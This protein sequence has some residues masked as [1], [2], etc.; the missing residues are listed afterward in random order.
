[1]SS[2]TSQQTKLDLELVPKENRLNIDKC[3]GRI[4]HKLTPREPTFQLILDVIALTSCY[5]AFLI[6]ADVPEVYMH[7]FWNS[8]YK[9][10]TFY[11][12]KIDKKKRFKLTL[13]VFRDIFQIFPRVSGRDFDPLPFEEDT[14]SF[15]RELGHMLLSIRCINPREL[16]L[17]LSI[18]FYL[19][20]LVVLTSFVSPELKSFGRNKIRM[21]TSKDDYLINSLRFVSAKESTQ[22]YGAIL[23]ECLTSPAMK[24]SK[25]YKTYLGYATG[26]VPPKMAQKFKKASPSKKDSDL[27]PVDEEPVQKGKRV[28]RPA[29][30][31]TTKPAA[32][33]VIREAPVETKSKSKEKEKVDVTRGKGIELLSEVALTEEA[34]MKEVRKKSLRDFHKTHPS[35]SGTVAEKPPSVDKITPIGNDEDDNKN[36]QD[37]SN[38]DSEQ[39]N[40]SEEQV[41]DSEQEEESEDDDQEEEEFVHTPFPTDDK[42][43]DNLESESD[44]VIKSDEKSDDVIKE[45]TQEQVF[46]DAHVKIPTITK[47]IEVPLTSSSYVHVHH[48]V[49][50]TQAPTLLTIPVFVITESSPVYTNIPQSSQTV[51]PLPILTTPN[52]PPTIETTNPL[53]TLLDFVSV[54]QFNDRI[55]ALEKEV[56]KLKKDPLHTQSFTARIKEQVKDQLPHILP[57]EVSNFA[58]PVIEKLIKESCDEV[59]LAKVSSQPHSTYEA[60]STL[61]EFELKKILLDKMEKSESYLAAPKHQDCYDS[62][63]KSYDLDKA[64]FF[65]YDVH[66]LKRS[67]KD[68]DK[69]EDP[70]A[71]SD[72]GLKKRKL[73]KD[74]EPT[75]GLKKKDS[76]S[77][78]SKGTKSQPKSSGKS[79]QSEEP[80]FEVADSDMPQD[81]EGNMG[82]N[83]D[84]PRKE[85]ASR[86]P[87]QN[88]LLTL[89]ASTSTDK[90]LKDFDELMSTPIDFSG[91][92]L[93]GLKIKNLTQEILLGPAFRLLKGTH[94]N[95][96]EL[97]YDFKECYKALL[98]KL[99]WENPEGGDYL[100]DLSKPL[101]LITHGKHQRVPFKYFINNDL[102]YLQAGVSTMTY[103]TGIQSR[104]DVYS[105]KRILAVTHVKLMRKHGY[106]YLE[107][108]VVRRADN[109]LYRFKEGDFPRLQINDIEDMLILVVQN[110]LINLLGDDVAD[111]AIA[112]R[113]FTR[114]LV[115]HKRVEDLQLG[116]KSYQKKINVTKPDT[117]R[118]DLIKRHPYTPYKDP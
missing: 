106:G 73:S 41:S 22:I 59:T 99:D 51:T 36:D 27:V 79:V 89:A 26:V 90:L 19:E 2:I 7:Q 83:E 20:R 16:L 37:L 94:S 3:N 18:G 10:D 113:M 67:R 31:S 107:E 40:E 64:F 42:D 53:S 60:A 86:R 66:S 78:S 48:K 72:R 71:G 97:E 95:Y 74:A 84:K 91:Y 12:F 17:L 117:T 96:V 25:A 8:V 70:S 101:P 11:R 62:L 87:T 75:T 69:D 32:G 33:V 49:P 82:D 29:K 103:T 28:K 114:S 92:I 81:Q 54:F 39:E 115:I 112:L 104:G 13:E 93:N 50:R 23:P 102:K 76:T 61:T 110:W 100:F 116:V 43:D 14:V 35:G 5:P 108:I 30:K 52:L 98:E 77:G 4:P 46:E 47:K 1:M 68:K 85:T 105:T 88:W 118:P 9:H 109:V 24:E 80:V 63:K 111:F 57:K 55:T 38:E 34:Q 44:D 6:T 45:T 58:P 15:L 65:S 21:H 56:A